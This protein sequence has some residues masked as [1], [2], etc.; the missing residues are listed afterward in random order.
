MSNKTE[1]KEGDTILI[2]G[3]AV[4]DA[5]TKN[6]SRTGNSDCVIIPVGW[7]KFFKK[8]IQLNIIRDENVFGKYT[9]VIEGV[10]E[11]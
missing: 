6:C 8:K 5:V 7:R 3:I 4:R 10:D 1:L 11:T 9:L 2:K